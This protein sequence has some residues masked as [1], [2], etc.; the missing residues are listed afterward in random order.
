MKLEFNE[1]LSSLSVHVL[2][3]T[4]TSWSFFAD[5]DNDSIQSRTTLMKFTN[6]QMKRRKE[7]NIEKK[8]REKKHWDKKKLSKQNETRINFKTQECVWKTF[9]FFK[10]LNPILTWN[11]IIYSLSTYTLDY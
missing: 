10:V 6:I 11:V 3:W 9:K 1:V 7:K 8:I 5:E 2:V 4:V